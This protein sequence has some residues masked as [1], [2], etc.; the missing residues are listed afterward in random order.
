MLK[1]S[2]MLSSLQGWI[3][4]TPCMEFLIK[5]YQS[6]RLQNSAARLLTKTRKYD[7]ITP[8]L[9]SLH[10]FPFLFGFST[11]FVSLPTSGFVAAHLTTS[12]N[13]YPY[14]PHDA[15]FALLALS[16]SILPEQN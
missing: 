3:I 9:I 1:N 15:P 8:I 12:K 2:F 4:A 13:Y 7:D 6:Y 11:R 5:T 16:V 10:W 14:K